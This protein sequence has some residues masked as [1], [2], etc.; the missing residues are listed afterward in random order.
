MGTRAS[1]ESAHDSDLGELADPEFF[2]YWADVR[3]RVAVT[4]LGTPEHA[5]VKQLYDAVLAEYRRRMDG[6]RHAWA[7]A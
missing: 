3:N 6:A 5:E 1:T 4:R 2:A 7:T